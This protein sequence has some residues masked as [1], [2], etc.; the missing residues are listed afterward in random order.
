[1]PYDL[2]G[3][4]YDET[5]D[6]S[7]THNLPPQQGSA[8]ANLVQPANQ[9]LGGGGTDI[10]QA[11]IAALQQLRSQAAQPQLSALQQ[12]QQGMGTEE[13]TAAS[14]KALMEKAKADR[15]QRQSQDNQDNQ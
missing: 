8:L 15:E 13:A 2:N 6:P 5:S 10:Q 11:R 1:M 14:F 4:Y 12:Q 9:A 3:Q 7:E